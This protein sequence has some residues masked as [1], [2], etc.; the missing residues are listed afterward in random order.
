M[1]SLLA[2]LPV[3]ETEKAITLG[4]AANTKM[5]L[6]P[7]MDI[8]LLD[9]VVFIM[10]LRGGTDMVTRTRHRSHQVSGVI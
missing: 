7:M 6:L 10:I 9:M 8:V 5:R 1:E 2:K 4:N 3:D